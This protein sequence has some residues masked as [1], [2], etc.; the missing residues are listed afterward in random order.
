[1][2]TQNHSI[3]ACFSFNALSAMRIITDV[4]FKLAGNETV[5]ALGIKHSKLSCVGKIGELKMMIEDNY[6]AMADMI[7]VSLVEEIK[8]FK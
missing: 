2:N 7:G 1:M 8:N 3:T 4:E 6:N 5:L